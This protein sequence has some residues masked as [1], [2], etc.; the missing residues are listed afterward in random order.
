MTSAV[1]Y[2]SVV[3][4]ALTLLA[5]AP[6]GTDVRVN[7]V[8]KGGQVETP[9]AANPLDPL[10]LVAAWIDF[11]PMS[12]GGNVAYGFTRDGGMTWQNG[13]L[14]FGKINSSTD[15]SVAADG[16]GTFYI[17]ALSS[18]GSQAKSSLRLLRSTD[19]GATFT[20]PF[21]AATEPFIDK[22]FMGVDPVTGAIY[23]VYYASGTKFVK[24]TDGGQT[25][26]LPVLAHSPTTFGDGPLPLS[27]PGGE[28]YVVSTND[29]NT[30][31]FN[32]SLDGGV[33]WLAQDVAAAHYP[34]DP[35]LSYQD[36]AFR[37]M[38]FPAAAVDLTN[39]ARRGRI[40]LA[41]PDTRF[42]DA[43]IML[44][45][46]DDRGD[47]WSAPVRVNDDAI[48]NHADQY[49]EWLA[50]DAGGGVQVT[51]LDHRGDPT[52][53]LYALY[54]ATSTDGGASFGPNIQ[55]SDGLFGSGKGN[56]FGGDYTGA[57][58]AGGRIFPL[59]PDARLGD[60]DVFTRGVSLT[61]YDEDGVLND[62]DMDGQ[63]ADHRCTGG[64]ST[65]CDDNCPGTTNPAQADGDGDFVG[66]ACDNCPG[67][68]NTGQ[69]DM[70]RDGI[71]D[72]CD[73]AP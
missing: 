15:P 38:I 68:A 66:D 1:R 41:W 40:Y 45:F 25:F 10:N 47:T 72:A 34:A 14:N 52:G 26:T 22:P 39:G 58:I 50:V 16:N 67:V 36:S 5:A 53:A 37:G 49:G 29:Q 6:S 3:C 63:Y 55:V 42:G 17:L 70:D 57:A 33:T 60:F 4:L 46:S 18:A 54:L 43:D 59:W 7:I 44:A 20:G 69:S 13:R 9:I 21:V 19:G 27:G 30:I 31:N 12:G 23:V 8:L 24:S 11:G 28:I 2:S 73:P 56:P 35:S 48:G 32:R 61:D 51:F 62:G 65:G 64:A 71:G